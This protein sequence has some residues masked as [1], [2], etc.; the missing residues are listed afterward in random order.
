MRSFKPSLP[1]N[2]PAQIM[3]GEYV[4][5]NGVSVKK[6]HDGDKIFCSAR[7]Y[8]GTEQIVNDKYV[9][10]DTMEI[11][12]W[13]RPDI[14]SIDAIRLLDDGSEWEILNNPENIN[15]QNKFLKIKVQRCVGNG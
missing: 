14:T 13:Y 1:Y 11:E 12:T 3:C 9:I 10:L 6:Y 4:K 2:V 5:I 8:G 15:R 7:S